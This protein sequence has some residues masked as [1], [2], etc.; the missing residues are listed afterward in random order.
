MVARQPAWSGGTAQGIRIAA[1]LCAVL[2]V[3]PGVAAD[4]ATAQVGTY[5]TTV[6]SLAPKVERLVER[7]K[8]ADWALRRA[9]LYY[10]FAG[11]YL[12]AGQGIAA[13]LWIGA[14]AYDPGTAISH[15][16][17]P[18]AWLETA[19]HFIDYSAL[20]RWG[21]VKVIPRALVARGP[22]EVRPGSTRVLAV[23]RS[24]DSDLGAYLAFHRER[25]DRRM[26]GEN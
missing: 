16:I 12:L 25:F 24:V 15:Q 22:A 2:A 7:T 23:Q 18:H 14:V 4:G 21:T 10:A 9:C 1:F 13:S 11:Q 6:A 20:P 17:W 3:S 26:K 8:P 5:V 19:T